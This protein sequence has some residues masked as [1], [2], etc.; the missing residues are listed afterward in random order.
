MD[1]KKPD[2]LQFVAFS[3]RLSRS[4]AAGNDKLKFV[5]LFALLLIHIFLLI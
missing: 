1:A 4:L 3:R 2:K 5:G